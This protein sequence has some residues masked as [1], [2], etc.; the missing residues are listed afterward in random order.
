M[1][2]S[3][4]TISSTASAATTAN[5]N[6]ASLFDESK[7]KRWQQQ[8]QQP[9]GY[10]T[11][12]DRPAATSSTIDRTVDATSS[13]SS[14]IQSNNPPTS[15]TPSAEFKT[16][17]FS[18]G[19][20]NSEGG[21]D[22]DSNSNINYNHDLDNINNTYRD[23]D[24]ERRTISM[25]VFF[26]VFMVL[27]IGFCFFYQRKRKVRARVMD[28]ENDNT[29][30]GAEGGGG[31]SRR[32]QLRENQV[33]LLFNF[34]LFWGIQ[35]LLEAFYVCHGCIAWMVIHSSPLSHVSTSAKLLIYYRLYSTRVTMPP[36]EHA[37]MPK[38]W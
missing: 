1:V 17:P 7:S 3:H 24:D 21:H 8:Q 16:S 13:L 11:R 10:S 32:Q 35:Y 36:D 25:T 18:N 14:S 33:R 27:Y 2:K 12:N 38:P 5:S 26:L 4:R 31:R 23:A 9:S 19:T 30:G 37:P 6:I 15:T 28:D 20:I 22:I 29:T 34:P